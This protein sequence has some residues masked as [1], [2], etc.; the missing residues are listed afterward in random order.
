MKLL[1]HDRYWQANLRLILLLLSIWGVIAIGFGVLW[2]EPLNQFQL[3]QIPLGFWISQQGAIVSFVILT[4]VY[5]KR[6]DTLDGK[7]GR[8]ANQQRSLQRR[9]QQNTDER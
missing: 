1:P 4:F 5:A 8:Y 9:P 3:G 7:Y 6:M 2:V